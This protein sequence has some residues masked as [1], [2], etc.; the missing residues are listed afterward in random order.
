MEEFKIREAR[1]EDAQQVLEY[2]KTV[3]GETENLTFGAEG[4]PITAEQEGE[5]LESV[6][7]S[8][9]SLH[10][11]VCKD[12]E[13]IADGGLTGLPRRMSHRAEVGLSVKKAYWNCGVGSMI[14]KELIEYAKKNG[15]E[16]LNLEV[17]SDNLR[18]IHLYEK[19]GFRKI[20]TSPASFKVNGA[21]ADF[22]L[23]YLD[24]RLDQ[25]QA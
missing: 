20:G 19:F 2:M 15:I 11:I 13:I 18:A 23:M 1:L 22:E 6:H 16:L 14:L 3:G 21:Y 10:L 25:K 12:G 24:L 8:P 7:N 4:L 9:T 17:R 5:F